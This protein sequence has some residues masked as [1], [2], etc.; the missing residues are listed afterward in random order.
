M[1]DNYYDILKSPKTLGNDL[2]QRYLDIDLA[3]NHCDRMVEVMSHSIT[4]IDLWLDTRN[5]IESQR[6]I[7]MTEL[8]EY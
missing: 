4:L 5:Y 2:I 7:K 3:I 1:S 6:V 8:Q